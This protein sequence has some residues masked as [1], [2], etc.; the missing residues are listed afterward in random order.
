LNVS[1]P[2]AAAP[3]QRRMEGSL[4]MLARPGRL[5]A[6]DTARTCPCAVVDELPVWPID[7]GT[8]R[9]FLT[10]YVLPIAGAV[11]DRTAP[12]F[13]MVNVI[14]IVTVIGTGSP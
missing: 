13:L 4:A 11:A 5:S 7:A 1:P 8:L 10:A 9:T 14:S 6:A 12:Y 2:F 3:L